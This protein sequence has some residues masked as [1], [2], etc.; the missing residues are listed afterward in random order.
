MNPGPVTSTRSH[1]SAT[2]TWATDGLG[3]LPRG[4]AQSLGQ[5][6]RRRWPESPPGPTPAAPGPLP[7]RGGQIPPG[8]FG[9]D[10]F[11]GRASPILALGSGWNR[12]SGTPS[13]P[14][15]THMGPR[16]GRAGDRR[17]PGRPRPPLGALGPRKDGT[18]CPGGRRRGS[19]EVAL[20]SPRRKPQRPGQG[21]PAQSPRLAGHDR[22]GGDQ[23]ESVEGARIHV[24][25]CRDTGGEEVLGVMMDSSRNVSTSPT[26]NPS[27]GQP[28]QVGGPGRSG[29]R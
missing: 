1:R 28:R 27:G 29:V 16:Q 25:F 4:A 20:V 14:P 24:E 5:G 7:A 17:R 8:A 19:A 21:G 15:A 11:S 18:D 10:R 12:K 2:S 13:P 9:E 6:Q 22:I 26:S 3:Y 23:I